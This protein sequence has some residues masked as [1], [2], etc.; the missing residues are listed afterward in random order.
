MSAKEKTIQDVYDFVRRT[1]DHY[2]WELTGDEDFLSTLCQG[3]LTNYRRHGFFLCPC[4]DSWG[5][6]E[7]DRD[8]MCPCDYCPEDLRDY[9]QCYC[10]LFLS[11][12]FV[13]SSRTPGAIPE[14]RPDEKFPY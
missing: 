10:G 12:Q 8:I 2:K 3:L 1:A 4:R 5:D 14:R 11:K 7:H 6:I 13:D 9:G